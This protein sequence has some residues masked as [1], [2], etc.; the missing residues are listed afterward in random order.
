MVTRS[1]YKA[2]QVLHILIVTKLF[3]FLKSL[4][5]DIENIFIA[6]RLLISTI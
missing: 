3:F 6:H 4:Q 5:N 1:Q 2:V